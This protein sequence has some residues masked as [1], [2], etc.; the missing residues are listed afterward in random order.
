LTSANQIILTFDEIS[1]KIV[2]LHLSQ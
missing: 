2:H 1:F